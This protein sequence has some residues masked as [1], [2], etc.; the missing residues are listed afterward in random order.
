ME[1]GCQIG[2]SRPFSRILLESAEILPAKKVTVPK[3][4]RKPKAS[5]SQ[6]QSLCPYKCKEFGKQTFLRKY[7]PVPRERI[8]QKPGVAESLSIFRKAGSFSGSAGLR[9]WGG[10][11]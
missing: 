9:R 5:G 11:Q 1:M 6:V 10:A 3:R 8:S 7:M 2:D 4:S